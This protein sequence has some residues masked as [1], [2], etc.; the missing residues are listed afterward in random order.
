MIF[1]EFIKVEILAGITT[2]VNSCNLVAPNVLAILIFSL[3]VFM[4]PCKMSRIVTIREIARAM[5]II[6]EVPEP[7][8]IIIIG[9]RATFGRLFN[10]TKNGSKTFDKNFDNHK[11]IEKQI[12]R[13]VPNVKP[14]NSFI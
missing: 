10:T 14:D 8:Q 7:T 9:P 3:S 1:K 4:K 12:P 5:T 13:S 2:L 6:A 11:I